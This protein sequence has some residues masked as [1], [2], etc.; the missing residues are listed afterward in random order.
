MKFME[1]IKKV[2]RRLCFPIVLLIFLIKRKSN[3]VNNPVYLSQYLHSINKSSNDRRVWLIGNGPS[4]LLS[5]LEKIP[6]RDIKIVANRF[7]LVYSKTNFRPDIVVSNDEQVIRDFGA[8]ICGAN[9]GLFVAF[10]VR[11]WCNMNANLYFRSFLPIRFVKKERFVY[12]NG[13]GSLFLGFQ[14][15]YSL[16][17]RNFILYG[18]DHN[19]SYDLEFIA[20][21]FY[22]I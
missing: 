2:I 13:G 20:E 4:V 16:G 8:E 3:N 7:H 11:Q 9:L 15:A 17:F 6:D 10:A 1:F 19:F 21:I 18:V 5:D 14:L 12:G 22:Y